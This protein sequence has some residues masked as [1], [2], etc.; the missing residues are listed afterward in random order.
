MTVTAKAVA[1]GLIFSKEKVN[2]MKYSYLSR[3][4]GIYGIVTG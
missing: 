3:A 2:F 1:F 4:T